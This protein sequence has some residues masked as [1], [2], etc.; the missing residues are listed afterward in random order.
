MRLL[1][2]V[3]NLLSLSRIVAVPVVCLLWSQ[4]FKGEAAVSTLLF[5]LTDFLDGRLARAW[6]KETPL[7]A[8]L[9]PIADKVMVT[10]LF[11]LMAKEGM[12]PFWIF[13]LVLIRHVSQLLSIPILMGWKKIPFKVRPG[14]LP[15]W[16][17]GLSFGLLVFAMATPEEFGR[18]SAYSALL[19]GGYITLSVMEVYI[20]VTYWPRFFQ[21][22]YGKHDTF[23]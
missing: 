1:L 11:G 19:Q 18:A 22:L 2:N 10:S 20:L 5:S 23:E 13:Y 9:D 16:A 12:F 3:P 17:T 14:S 6:G 4:G 15:K 8:L 21:I 7:G